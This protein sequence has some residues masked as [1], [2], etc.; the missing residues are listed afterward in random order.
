MAAEPASATGMPHPR[1]PA[2]RRIAELDRGRRRPRRRSAHS[3]NRAARERATGDRRGVA[4]AAYPAH[5]AQSLRLEEILACATTSPR[6]ALEA[7]RGA[8]PGRAALERGHRRAGPAAARRPVRVDVARWTSTSSCC[9]MTSSAIR[10]RLRRR[11][12]RRC[13]RT[14]DAWAGGLGRRRG[15][16]R[17]R[18]R[19]CI[20]NSLV[21]GER[22][23]HGAHARAAGCVG[24][25]VEVSDEGPGVPEELGLDVFERSR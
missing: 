19:R 2:L 7:D 23:D 11:R 12:S 8:E 18:S 9:G 5:R 17:R 6:C 21:H 15:A 4:P 24:R 1:A 16:R 3:F 25:S 20:E 13:G 10:P 22:H 14:R